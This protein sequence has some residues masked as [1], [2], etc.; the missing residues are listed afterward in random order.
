VSNLIQG[1][2][3]EQHVKVLTQLIHGYLTETNNPAEL[4]VLKLLI[5]ETQQSKNKAG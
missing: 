3:Q 1:C 5:N 2:K 4:E